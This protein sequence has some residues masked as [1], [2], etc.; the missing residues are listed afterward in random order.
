MTATECNGNLDSGW[1][2]AKSGRV[3][4]LYWIITLPSYMFN[5]DLQTKQRCTDLVVWAMVFNATF[6][7]I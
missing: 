5:V 1:A 6:N 7:N 4:P 3:K 2:G